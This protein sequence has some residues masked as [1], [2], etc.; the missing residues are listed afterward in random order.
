MSQAMCVCDCAGG[1]DPTQSLFFVLC[2]ACWCVA[3]QNKARHTSMYILS[4]DVGI[5]H[6]GLARIRTKPLW[7]LESMKLVNITKFTHNLVKRHECK[8]R[9][10]NGLADRLDHVIQDHPYLF[11][12]NDIVLVER[13]PIRGLV[14]VEQYFYKMFE[15]TELVHPRSVHAFYDVKCDY[16][17]RKEMSTLLARQIMM[18][19]S[20]D[21]G[22][23]SYFESLERK[24]DLSDAVVQA[25]YWVAM[26]NGYK[27]GL[28][29]ISNRRF[30]GRDLMLRALGEY[31]PGPAADEEAC[32]ITTETLHLLDKFAYRPEDQEKP[33]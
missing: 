9:H 14:G 5:L 13:Q 18:E 19:H 8:L 32:T 16:E 1:I 12:D 11:Q 31:R 20:V 33:E 22:A 7:H 25:W 30:A 4:I 2:I 6:L 21:S 23:A 3:W 29:S 17:G 28:S 15:S 24:H 27:L 26:N 10:S